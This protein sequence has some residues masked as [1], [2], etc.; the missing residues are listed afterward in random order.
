MNLRRWAARAAVAAVVAGSGLIVNPAPAV[1]HDAGDWTCDSGALCLWYHA[2][3]SGNRFQFFGINASFGGWTI[4]NNDSAWRN[5]GT[6]GMRA[7]VWGDDSYNGILNLC[8]AMGTRYAHDPGAYYNSS[9]PVNDEGN[10]N[11]WAWTC[12]A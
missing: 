8:V 12:G 5:N 2:H 4:Y 10:S 1:A 11:D 9:D 6:S 3:Y 7:R